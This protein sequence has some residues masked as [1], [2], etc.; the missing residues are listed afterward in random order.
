MLTENLKTLLGDNLEGGGKV[1][2]RET[3]PCMH[4][5]P[6]NR[7]LEHLERV[8]KLHLHKRA[9]KPHLSHRR[10]P[11]VLG[12]HTAGYVLELQ[13]TGLEMVGIKPQSTA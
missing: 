7:R 11:P 13:Q 2:D 9:G 8:G 4:F 10:H 1:D 12:T 6:L 5:H 3:H